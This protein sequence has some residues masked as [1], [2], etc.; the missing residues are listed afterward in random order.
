[1]KQPIGSVFRERIVDFRRRLSPVSEQQSQMPHRDGGWSKKEILG[2]LIDS[3]LN[4]HQRFVRASLDG[5]YS[6]PSYAQQGWVAMHGYGEMAWTRLFEYWRTQNEL[7]CEVVDRIP[8]NR[9]ESPCRIGENAQ[10]TLQFLVTDYLD[11]LQ[12]H[13]EQIESQ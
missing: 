1:M 7:L 10:V 4:N 13:V 12:H 8:E 6:G 9:L 3:A 5:D 11:H 2:H